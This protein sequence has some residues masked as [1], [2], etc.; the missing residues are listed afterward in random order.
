MHGTDA[1]KVAP[2]DVSKFRL[3][4]LRVL[5]TGDAV[6]IENSRQLTIAAALSGRWRIAGS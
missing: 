5:I 6:E 1:S 3:W 4:C 2:A